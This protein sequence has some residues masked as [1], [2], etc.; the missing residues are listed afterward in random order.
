[1]KQAGIVATITSWYSVN[2]KLV[3]ITR[4]YL[5]L[6]TQAGLF[7]RWC[8]EQVHIFTG[9]VRDLHHHAQHFYST[10]LSNIAKCCGR[11]KPIWNVSCKSHKISH[12]F[13]CKLAQVVALSSPLF[14]VYLTIWLPFSCNAA[15]LIAKA[16]TQ[17]KEVAFGQPIRRYHTVC[18]YCVSRPGLLNEQ[19]MSRTVHSVKYWKFP[20]NLFCFSYRRENHALFTVVQSGTGQSI[21]RI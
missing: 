14:N 4:F 20:P 2:L 19:G 21:V 18:C 13:C 11:Y 1:M 8:G 10:M 16:T 7:P 15:P 17:L 5:S 6:P 3:K 12:S 9:P